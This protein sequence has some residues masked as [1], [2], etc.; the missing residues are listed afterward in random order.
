M[1]AIS[2]KQGRRLATGL[3]FLAPNVL[4]FMAFTLFPLVFSLVLAF[5]NWDLRF[6]NMFK[7]ARI[8]FVGVANFARL[9]R[10]PDF[11]KFL[12]NTL[13]LMM[14][15]PL[16]V[17]GSLGSAL[18]LVKDMGG[19]S[20]RAWGVLVAA[21]VMLASVALLTAAGLGA[22]AFTLLLLGLAGL[23]L[24]MGSAGGATVY[25]TLF[26]IPN[27]TSGV[28][29]YLLWKKMYSQTGP[30]NL[31]LAGPLERLGHAVNAAGPRPLLLLCWVLMLAMAWVA[32]ASVRRLGRQW[33]EGEVGSLGLVLPLV[34]SLLP[35]CFFAVMWA[36]QG[37]LRAGMPALA[38]AVLAW[39]AVRSWQ[40]GQ[41]FRT[42]LWKGHG[43][44]L[45]FAGLLMV[46]QLV[47]F[48]LALT[49]HRL[50][51]A[52]AAG[53]APPGWLTDYHWAKPAIMI[54]GLWGAI[55]SN[56]MLLYLAGLTNIPLELYEAADIDGASRSQRFW[57]VTW[58]QL[59][60][61]TFFIFIMSVIGGLQGGFE[62]ARTMTKGGPAG[63]TTPLSYFIYTEGFETGRLGNASG[64]AWAL[65][66]L[67]FVVTMLNWK[68]G[69][70]YVN[71]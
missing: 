7:E 26:F 55:G 6:H 36:P 58:P 31:A 62:M 21:A 20:R 1:P 17:A 43:D 54:M 68:F 69:S 39:E 40:H 46:A 35:A 33:R 44:N 41:D 56:N 14:G 45:V 22:T 10:E 28:A 64:V 52:A 42:T 3:A 57:H 8:E 67:V 5:S 29:V 50:P 38:L 9:F 11:L 34:F 63:A 32:A 70:R 30:V 23:F 4:G 18:L 65:F 59:A 27:F 61:I 19:G 37:S 47:L 2:A 49:A 66:A 60:P 12:G 15:I 13:F 48:G 51:A 24:V 71:D 16:G 53:L 25:R